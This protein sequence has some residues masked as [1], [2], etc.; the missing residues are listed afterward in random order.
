MGAITLLNIITHGLD[1]SD[2]ILRNINIAPASFQNC[3]IL[4][5]R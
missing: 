3:V 5:E 4:L 2:F 1:K